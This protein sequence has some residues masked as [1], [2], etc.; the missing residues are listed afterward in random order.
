MADM[1]QAMMHDLIDHA[2][3][4]AIDA[5]PITARGRVTGSEV[6]IRAIMA[7]FTH[8]NDDQRDEVRRAMLTWETQYGFNYPEGVR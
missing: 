5:A 8:L 7:L 2:K 4:E 1:T 3:Q 6:A